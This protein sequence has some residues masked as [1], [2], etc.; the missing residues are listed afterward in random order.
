MSEPLTR[1]RIVVFGI[2]QGVGYRYSTMRQASGLPVTGWVR[3]LP[4]GSVEAVVE[5]PAWAVDELQEWMAQ[6]PSGAAVEAL[7]AV[8]ETPEGL[9][10][11]VIAR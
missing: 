10:G 6:G 1:R 8:D 11:F 4:D 7:E 3:N 5:G 2:V 9:A